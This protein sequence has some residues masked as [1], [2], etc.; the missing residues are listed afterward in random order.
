[1]IGLRKRGHYTNKNKWKTTST[2]H[3]H[4]YK[5]I[6]LPTNRKTIMLFDFQET[7]S[8]CSLHIYVYVYGVGFI[9][10]PWK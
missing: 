4:P 10:S 5:I 9:L 8:N 1:M 3:E 2:I 7:K 6:R